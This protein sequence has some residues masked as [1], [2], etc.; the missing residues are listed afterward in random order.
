MLIESHPANALRAS[1]A[2]A[3]CKEC[4][5]LS[6]SEMLA[7]EPREQ[8]QSCLGAGKQDGL[9]PGMTQVAGTNLAIPSFELLER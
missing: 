7:H 1:F 2:Q 8:R 9:V 4:A 5:S 3:G 6:R